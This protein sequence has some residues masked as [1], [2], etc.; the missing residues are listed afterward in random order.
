MNPPKKK[1]QIL[2][3]DDSEDDRFFMRMALQEQSHLA[4]VAELCDG[5]EAIAYLSGQGCFAD[6]KM[7]PFPDLIFLD[8]KMPRKSGFDVLVWLKTQQFSQLPIVVLSGS[9]LP[10]DMEK[11]YALGAA[12]YHIKTATREEQA[13]MIATIEKVLE[14]KPR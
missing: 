2:L 9:F 11:S 7:H 6:R 13:A 3:V 14:K 8:L 10:E 5:E 1:Y 12:A 4:I